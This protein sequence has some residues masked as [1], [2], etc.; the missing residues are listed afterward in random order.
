MRVRDSLRRL[1]SP[2]PH[3]SDRKAKANPNYDSPNNQNNALEDKF[4]YLSKPPSARTPSKWARPAEPPTV[5]ETVSVT[6]TLEESTSDFEN[7]YDI[8]QDDLR[9]SSDSNLRNERDGQRRVQRNM[10]KERGSLLSSINSPDDNSF[11]RQPNQHVR[12][13]RAGDRRKRKH[14]TSRKVDIYI[15]TTIS[16]RNLARLLNVRL[17]K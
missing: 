1:S 10:F 11:S 6:E 7:N 2:R 16:V 12:Q 15:P 17:R 4:R 14:I 13:T 5:P 9:G 8:D 3:L